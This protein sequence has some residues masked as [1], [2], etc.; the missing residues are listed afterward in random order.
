LGVGLALDRSAGP[1]HSA[2]GSDATRSIAG[3][4]VLGAIEATAVRLI[5]AGEAE[6]ARQRLP[7]LM[8]FTVL[9]FFF[10]REAADRE[11]EQS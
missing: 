4:N 1:A 3:G 5:V 2:F 11:L 10:G 8:H 6:L 7:E 9:F